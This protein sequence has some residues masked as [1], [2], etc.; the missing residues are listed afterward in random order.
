MIEIM[1][2]VCI[3]QV[4][5]N[6]TAGTDGSAISYTITYIDSIS[7]SICGLTSI[8]ASSCGSR[9]CT[10]WFDLSSSMCKNSSNIT[11]AAF[12]TNVFGDGPLSDIFVYIPNGGC[13]HV[14]VCV[15][16]YVCVCV[17]V[18]ALCDVSL[19]KDSKEKI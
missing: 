14:C 15:C 13:V 19:Q 17:C 18:H 5:F 9:I 16:V 6:I 3:W 4:P 12:A 10:D 8:A 1:H 7:G 2:E 11:V